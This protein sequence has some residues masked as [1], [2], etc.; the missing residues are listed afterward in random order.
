ML[1]ITEIK[2]SKNPVG[3]GEKFTISV[4]IQETADYPYDY[5]YGI[6]HGH[7]ETERNIKM[8]FRGTEYCIIKLP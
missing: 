5:P 8:I 6:L 4:K 1:T 3:T 7:S 2:L